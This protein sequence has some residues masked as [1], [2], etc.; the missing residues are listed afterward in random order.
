MFFRIVFFRIYPPLFIHAGDAFVGQGSSLS[1]LYTHHH[2]ATLLY[3]H[4]PLLIHLG[5]ELSLHVSPRHRVE[6]WIVVEVGVYRGLPFLKIALPSVCKIR[7]LPLGRL[8][9]CSDAGSLC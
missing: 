3:A 5:R 9:C 4:F 6:V 7:N 1:P 2:I 8:G